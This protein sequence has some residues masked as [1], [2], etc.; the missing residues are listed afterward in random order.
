M[1]RAVSPVVTGSIDNVT[2][3]QFNYHLMMS[4]STQLARWLH[5]QLVLK[6]TFAS[7]TSPFEIRYS[8]IKR[9]SG[10]LDAYARVRDAICAVEEAFAELKTR[11]V[12]LSC[13][14]KDVTGPRNKLLDATFKLLP[15]SDFVHDTKAGSK[16]LSLAA[17]VQSPQNR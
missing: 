15:S 16:R 2:Y 1:G 4:H 14:R 8:T 5:K 10:L 11:A 9:D 12:L 3:R 13:T 7:I 17:P 6:Y